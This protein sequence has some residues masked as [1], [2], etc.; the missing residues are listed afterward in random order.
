MELQDGHDKQTGEITLSKHKRGVRKI[1]ILVNQGNA[2]CDAVL[3]GSIAGPR[4]LCASPEKQVHDSLLEAT[5]MCDPS[6][7]PCSTAK[8]Q[9]LTPLGPAGTQQPLSLYN[10]LTA[11]LT[12]SQNLSISNK[13][14]KL[15][16]PFFSVFSYIL[17]NIPLLCLSDE[18]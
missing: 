9:L 16:I 14:K 17:N 15:C 13:G 10:M 6:P 4:A 18:D 3:S 8:P 5:A 11:T 1:G 12:P 2:I 7:L